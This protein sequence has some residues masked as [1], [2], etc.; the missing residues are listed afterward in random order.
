[1]PDHKTKAGIRRRKRILIEKY[2]RNKTILSIAGIVIG[3]I[4]MIWQKGVL[5]T[6]IQVMGYILIAT[7]VVYL[8]MYFKNNRQNETEMGYAIVS[9]GAGLLLVLLNKVIVN[10]FPVV[11]GIVLIMNGALSLMQ[12]YNK[13]EVPL[14]SKILSALIIAL[15]ILI[16]IHPGKIADAVVFCV[17]AAFAVSGI[18]GLLS[19]REI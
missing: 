16:V 10:A 5:T 3:A 17:G 15:G 2:L 14:Y 4:L 8:V 11:M 7:A 18:A 19:C 12:T 6:L 1:M 9:A 13:K